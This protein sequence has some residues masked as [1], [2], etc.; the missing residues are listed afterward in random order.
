MYFGFVRRM[1]LRSLE[2]PPIGTNAYLVG[3]EKSASI[4]VVDAPLNCFLS[5][6]RFAVDRG[7]KIEALLLT[8]GHWDH[9][10]DAHRFAEA[11]VRVFAHPGD[12]YMLEHPEIMK[13]YAVPGIEI[14]KV[15]VDRWISH[16]ETLNLGGMT[17]EVRQV[18]GHSPGGVVFYCEAEGV[19]FG[20]DALFAGS[21]GRTDLPGGDFKQLE[22][23]IRSQLYTMPAE[24]IVYPGHG[25]KTTV[26]QE[27]NTNPF[28]RPPS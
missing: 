21:I 19:V 14:Q 28:V 16:G 22:A 11:G 26:A 17:F 1:E 3:S 13:S 5:A 23:G 8:H 6:E 27:M 25:P 24:T 7:W 9:T 12:R 2:L 18:P 4:V 10:L 20:G 15:R